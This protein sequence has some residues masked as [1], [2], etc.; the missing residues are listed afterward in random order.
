MVVAPIGVG[1]MS[2][3][4]VGVKEVVGVDEDDAGDELVLDEDEGGGRAVA[5][6]G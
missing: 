1:S 6:T 2:L 5:A 3:T 4:V